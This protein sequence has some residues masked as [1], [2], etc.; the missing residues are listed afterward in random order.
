M[1]AP[2]DSALIDAAA[3]VY[4]ELIDTRA[5]VVLS[6]VGPFGYRTAKETLP[7]RIFSGSRMGYRFENDASG[8]KVV[9]MLEMLVLK[10]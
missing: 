9:R 4:G 1:R 5:G 10:Q 2:K 3:H 7:A 8:E 6:T